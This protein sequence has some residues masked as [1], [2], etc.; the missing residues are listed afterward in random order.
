MPVTLT[1][2]IDT[3]LPAKAAEPMPAVTMTNTEHLLNAF[4]YLEPVT[5]SLPERLAFP[6][7]HSKTYWSI[8]AR[9]VIQFIAYDSQMYNLKTQPRSLVIDSLVKVTPVLCV[10]LSTG[11]CVAL[12]KQIQSK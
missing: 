5:I 2:S 4:L 7:V 10:C 8:Y 11:P 9:A 6:T 3:N 1:S 12:S